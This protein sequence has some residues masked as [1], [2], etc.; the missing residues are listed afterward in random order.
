MASANTQLAKVAVT[1]PATQIPVTLPSV[2]DHVY[3]T[4]QPP[5]PVHS[6]SVARKGS[7]ALRITGKARSAYPVNRNT[8]NLCEEKARE[9]EQGK[10]NAPTSDFGGELGASNL[11][12]IPSRKDHSSRS[13]SGHRGS[14]STTAAQSPQA[15]TSGSHSNAGG[16]RHP[17]SPPPYHFG[18]L[19]S[20][21]MP[22]VPPG[23]LARSTLLGSGVD[24][25]GPLTAA[26]A[27]NVK[28]ILCVRL[29]N[30]PNESTKGS[31]NGGASSLASNVMP[32][33]S[34]DPRRKQVTLIHPA[35]SRRRFSLAAPKMFAFDAVLTQEDPLAEVCSLAL[36]DAV[37]SVVHGTDSCVLSL[38]HSKTG[39]TWT[40]LGSDKSTSTAGVIPCAIAWL[41]RLIEEQKEATKTR[42]SVRVSAIEVYGQKESLKDL[43]QGEG[44]E[45]TETGPTPSSYLREQS[46]QHKPDSEGET[47]ATSESKAVASSTLTP[48]AR[49]SQ[50]M[51]SLTELRAPSAHFAAHLL[52]VALSNRA[53]DQGLCDAALSHILFTL[54][55]YQYKVE[56]NGTEAEVSGGRSRLQL[57]HLGCG[58]YSQHSKD[59]KEAELPPKTMP[60]SLSISGIA[61]VLLGLLTG[62]RE[63]PHRESAVTQLLR[64]AMTGNHMQPCIIAHV[65]ANQQHYA[66]TL[67]VVQIASR[68]NRL[69]RRRVGNSTI[70][71]GSAPATSSL[72]GTTSDDTSSSVDS[73][74]M[75]KLSIS[76]FR[77]PRLGRSSFGYRSGASDAEYTSSSEQSCDTVIYLGSGQERGLGIGASSDSGSDRYQ[78]G[79]RGL[80]DGSVGRRAL[81]SADEYD[82]RTVG[83]HR[84]DSEAVEERSRIPDLKSRTRNSK[85]FSFT[86]GGTLRASSGVCGLGTVPIKRVAP[87]TNATAWPRA[88][89]VRKGKELLTSN[90]E[91]WVDGPNA[92][93]VQELPDTATVQNVI[94]ETASV[95]AAPQVQLPLRPPPT[96]PPPAPPYHNF[97][98]RIVPQQRPLF[99]STGDGVEEG[100]CRDGSVARNP[101]VCSQPDELDICGRHATVQPAQSDATKEESRTAELSTLESTETVD[102][103]TETRVPPSAITTTTSH[104]AEEE[105]HCDHD[106]RSEGEAS[107]HRSPISSG[108]S[109]S[110]SDSYSS[111]PKNNRSCRNRGFGVLSDISERTEETETTAPSSLMG[112]CER[113]S[114]STLLD[115]ALQQSRL[116]TAEGDS[117]EIDRG[118]TWPPLPTEEVAFGSP[119]LSFLQLTGDRMTIA[120]ASPFT[121]TI[122]TRGSSH[123]TE[124]G[125]SST[126]HL[127]DR[128]A[129]NPAEKKPGQGVITPICS[130][131]P[132]TSSHSGQRLLQSNARPAKEANTDGGRGRHQ[133][134]EKASST[135]NAMP[136]NSNNCLEGRGHRHSPRRRDE[137]PDPACSRTP[138]TNTSFDRVAAWVKD[139][140]SDLVSSGNILDGVQSTPSTLAA[141]CTPDRRRRRS[142]SGEQSCSQGCSNEMRHRNHH[143]SDRH[144]NSRSSR[145]Q[146]SHHRCHSR[147]SEDVVCAKCHER[148]CCVCESCTGA[149]ASREGSC[150][151]CDQKRR[152]S[153]LRSREHSLRDHSTKADGGKQGEERTRS[154][155]LKFQR[156]DVLP[157]QLAPVQCPQTVPCHSHLQRYPSDVS[158]SYNCST[159]PISTIQRTASCPWVATQTQRP[160]SIT[161]SQPAADPVM[162][163]QYQQM[164][165]SQTPP[166]W[167]STISSNNP[168]LPPY[169]APST[170]AS[171]HG[172]QTPLTPSSYNNNNFLISMAPRLAGW[173]LPASPY[174]HSSMQAWS[175]QLP[176]A[177]SVTPTEMGSPPAFRMQSGD[178][179]PRVRQSPLQV[180]WPNDYA[181]SKADGEKQT[182]GETQPTTPKAEKSKNNSSS[183]SLPFRF[184]T[185]PIFCNLRRWQRQKKEKKQDSKPSAAATAASKATSLSASNSPQHAAAGGGG[186]GEFLCAVTSN[187]TDHDAYAVRANSGVS[188][189]RDETSLPVKASPLPGVR[190]R[191]GFSGYAAQTAMETPAC[192]SLSYTLPCPPAQQSS[193][194]CQPKIIS[195]TAYQFRLHHS[196]DE[197]L[198]GTNFHLHP[199]ETVCI[200]CNMPTAKSRTL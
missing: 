20:T 142:T 56:K 40:M 3:Q 16:R 46:N 175:A 155:D 96:P 44:P 60:K 108:S 151:P 70:S 183:A 4:L 111:S 121:P 123:F 63:L 82:Q 146:Y 190:S 102:S 24:R 66:E 176:M 19:L 28:V 27:G 157:Q 170:I 36:T 154:R 49:L 55:V 51:D 64:E 85:S 8:S 22:P 196:K 124:A 78:L 166:I 168:I 2:T 178:E 140:S 84:E 148:L 173:S 119:P 14:L 129:V 159:L 186:G 23:L 91:T 33:V 133:V 194:L 161:S 195:D 53:C 21:S 92:M 30:C 35:P 162:T 172:L 97:A 198:P 26:A 76:R 117:E 101:V 32:S 37:Y 193:M 126:N 61:S 93:V 5:K 65:S 128:V 83:S 47:T 29:P 163:G 109:S 59:Q 114:V 110:S 68:L 136:K 174:L 42:F 72:S 50:A 38:G 125:L 185:L 7:P 43:L 135:E 11:R 120:E 71:H 122:T 150:E 134:K 31:S 73:P 39:K 90:E 103:A 139:V 171:F 106:C 153:K 34:I 137:R 79:Q 25:R 74:G 80:A 141:Y 15:Y 6:T 57:L 189:V 132:T 107:S 180:H 69:K 145:H 86:D 77:G 156:Q 192:A 88:A 169:Y 115:L 165:F 181:S 54:H 94:P 18:C 113:N 95:E 62:Q 41:F 149:T 177:S 187:V 147:Q 112:H 105:S 158:I 144:R 48:A 58:R 100:D 167:S 52:D 116:T 104:A 118:T 9:R 99:S 160:A 152:H 10:S 81:H 200:H 130:E 75:R 143:K 131:E 179:K 164:S 67:Q 1:Q 191:F 89:T 87:R 197:S 12:F 188:F 138:Q 17:S 127:D 45:G 13:G 98:H 199:D 182:V 184:F